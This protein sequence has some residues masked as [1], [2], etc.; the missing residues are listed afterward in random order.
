MKILGLNLGHN[1]TACLVKD[2]RVVGCVSE[3]RFSRV[4]NHSGIPFDSIKYLLGSN[5]MDIS[6]V[7]KIVLDNHYG[8]DKDPNFGK[9]F[10]EAYTKKNLFRRISSFTGYKLPKMFKLYEN[11]K[12]N[13]LSSDSKGPITR[14]LKEELSKTLKYPKEKI[15][16]IDH[17]LAHA[18]SVGFNAKRNTPTLIFTLD[19]EG[20]GLCATVS[21]FDGR[22]AKIIAKTPKSASLGYLY[23]IVTIFLGMKPLE[24]EFKVMGLAPYAKEHNID[25]VYQKIKN[26]IW[27]NKNLEFESAFN[28]PFSDNYL[29]RNMRFERFDNIS[30]AVQKLVEERVCEWISKSIA[31]TGVN[32]IA[33]SG[34]VF[35]NVKANMKIS[36]LPEVKK[37][38]IMPSCGDESNPIGCCFYGY[39]KMCRENGV[40]FNPYKI[41]DLYLGPE[42]DENYIQNLIKSKNLSQKYR[43]S[44]PKKINEVVAKLLSKGY[45]VARCCSRSEWGARA[46]GNRSILAN[47]AL[48]DTIRV[49]NETI[50]DRD[51]WMPFTPSVLDSAEKKYFYN[52]KKID[53]NYMVITFNSTEIA[54]KQ[55]PAAMHPYDF[56]IRPQVVLKEHNPEYYNLLQEFQ[57]I[58][59]V[60]ALLNTSFN[61]HGEPNV[62]T[63]EDALHTVE[64]SALKYLILD[65]FL[66]EKKTEILK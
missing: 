25:K 11:F 28:M 31:K 63:P 3:E 1:A 42:Y 55:L 18:L 26:L 53:A 27:V 7:D 47:P 56:T 16:V 62:L 36:E 50:K 38:F 41:T 61:L 43:I 52:P 65:N 35:M 58:T 12:R 46:L 17:H 24:H 29:S 20:S 34:G 57:R 2:G 54:R 10:L 64:N 30:G 48:P 22:T 45:I 19:G 8:I 49:L 14:F 33:L 60:G 6:D 66:L 37:M 4:K 21:L 5:S 51:F 23:S 15:E 59:G 13:V 39:E 44:K 9:R 32:E 40:A